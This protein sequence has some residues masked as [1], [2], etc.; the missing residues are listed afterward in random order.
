MPPKQNLTAA[1]LPCLHQATRPSS[2]EAQ[3]PVCAQ[4]N[5]EHGDIQRSGAGIYT[6]SGL[7]GFSRGQGH[8]V[9]KDM[10][11]IYAQDDGM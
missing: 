9:T 10:T 8:P 5:Y 3:T 1:Q 4:A 7:T 11:P 2:Y 6:L